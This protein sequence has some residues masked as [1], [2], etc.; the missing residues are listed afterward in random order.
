MPVIIIN[1]NSSDSMTETALA[2][3]QS[4]APDVEFWGWTS[5]LGPRVIEGPE[6]GA[7][8]V[9]LLLD[10]VEKANTFDPSMIIIACF[11]DTGLADAQRISK[12]PVLGIGQASYIFASILSGPTAVI[13]TVPQAVPVIRE[14]ISEQGFSKLVTHV[15]AADVPV[16]TLTED[17]SSALAQFLDAAQHIPPHTQNIILGCSGAVSIRSE[18]QQRTPKNVIDGV[19]AA[20]RLSRA[21]AT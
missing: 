10:L 1:P 20:A 5:T 14:N 13:T 8:A 7:A 9:P 15:S 17:P 12:C 2:A 16:I 18:F 21:V 19:Y 6:D 11:D 4:A 3:A